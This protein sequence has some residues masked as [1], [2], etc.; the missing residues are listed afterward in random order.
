[1]TQAT[2]VGNRQAGK[3]LPVTPEAP[4]LAWTISERAERAIRF[5]ETY[6]VP[7]KG[8][9]AGSPLR[10]AE[11]QKAW[12]RQVFGE[13]VQSAAMSVGRGNGKSTFLGAVAIWA[14]FD[15]DE[16]GAP[17]VPIVA[18]TV[19]QAIR[20]TYGV[21]LAMIAAQPELSDRC[22]VY[23]AIGAMKV[24]V[25]FTGG[26]MFPISNNP[27]GLQ[28]L[29]PSLAVCDEIGFMPI[30]S[31]DSLLLASGKRPR[32][33]VAGIGT[34]GFDRNNALWHLRQRVNEGVELPG[35]RFVE[36]AAHEGCRIDDEAEWQLAN[37]ALSEGYMNPD[38][39][40]T[41]VALSPEAH[42]RIFRLGQWVDGAESWLGADGRRLWD[43][44]C[45]PYE[46]DLGA[47]TWAGVDVGL[48]R[49][50]TA[51]VTIQRRPDG[52]LHAKCRLWIPTATE[53]VDVTDVMAYLRQVDAAYDLKAVSY[54][55]RFF[56]VPAKMLED[57]G[58]AMIEVPQSVEYMTP[59]V[60]S[61]FEL[62]KR[63]ELSHDGD[64]ALAMH[65]LDAVPRFNE[66]GFTLAKGKSKG[67]IDAAVALCLAAD[68][69]LRAR[70]A[71]PVAEP[72]AAFA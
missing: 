3:K 51:V 35:F 2:K 66:R 19:N 9:G 43:G 68:R 39:L 1:M 55:P 58:L 29:D 46:F 7:P 50:S 40:R 8:Y 37:P 16:S 17:Q 10:L 72:W 65:V 69:V 60:G 38:A 61:T 24:V 30:E 53:P 59:A 25:P 23:S 34:P 67:R 32:S 71:V 52:R 63:A 42:F 6:C 15:P 48:K 54:D 33:L 13:G 21:A 36:Y 22:F 27:D 41:A 14:V 47:E 62:V 12:L 44:L 18:T 26:E 5:I 28:G 31:W 64:P 11:Y 45:D 20:A 4:W 49:D 57:E 70:A 56:D